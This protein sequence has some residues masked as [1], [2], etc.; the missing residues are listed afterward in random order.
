MVEI[1]NILNRDIKRFC[2][3]LIQ[4]SSRN[5]CC[6]AIFRIY[7]QSPLS[8]GVGTNIVRDFMQFRWDWVT[9]M[10]KRMGW[11]ELTSNLLLI[12]MPG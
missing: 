11:G 8:E 9:S 6:C 4:L 7:L 1:Y 3:C 2:F 12:G 10:Q 5:I